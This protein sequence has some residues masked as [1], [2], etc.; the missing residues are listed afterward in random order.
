MIPVVSIN[1][2]ETSL[3][4]LDIPNEIYVFLGGE[5]AFANPSVKY[6]Q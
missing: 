1:D 4:D 3:D 6:M 5:H 2:F